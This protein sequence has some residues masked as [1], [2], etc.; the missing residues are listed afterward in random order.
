MGLTLPSSSDTWTTSKTSVT[1][2]GGGKMSLPGEAAASRGRSRKTSSPS[3]SFFLC[4]HAH[5]WGI[6]LFGH[7]VEGL[8]ILAA[9]LSIPS[10]THTT[11]LCLQSRTFA[12][13]P[14]LLL[15]SATMKTATTPCHS[16]VAGW[17]SAPLSGRTGTG[18]GSAPLSFSL[19]L[20]HTLSHS[21]SHSHCTP[22]DLMRR[23]NSLCLL[24]AAGIEC[25]RDALST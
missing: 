18:T 17:M 7:T 5:L 14:P 1:S 6:L 4:A 3:V 10:P 19:S 9:S 13:S 8:C 2:I 24:W 12:S 21:H 15:P 20:S 11:V 25:L 16:S 22:T 23:E